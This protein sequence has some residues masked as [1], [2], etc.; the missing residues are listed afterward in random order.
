[1]T[2]YQCNRSCVYCY[3]RHKESLFMSPELAK[4]ILAKE[5][6]TCSNDGKTTSLEI[7]FMGGEPLLN[8]PLIK[9]VCNWIWTRQ[10]E[11]PY[12]L[13]VRTNGSLLDEEKQKWFW[14]N[15]SRI[16]MGLSMDGL[17]GMNRFNRG[18]FE[19]HLD[20]FRRTWPQVPVKV[21]L[22]PDSIDLL[23]ETVV[24]AEEKDVPLELFFAE[25]VE[26][27]PDSVRVLG[28]EYE[29]L[30]NHY[31]RQRNII[32]PR[33]LFSENLRDLYSPNNNEN[34]ER[35][36]LCGE[37]HNEVCYDVDGTERICHIFTPVTM[38]RDLADRARRELSAGDIAITE[39]SEC[40][41]CPIKMDCKRCFGF[42][43]LIRGDVSKNAAR[44]TTCLATWERARATALF[45]LKRLES[46]YGD[47][48]T[49]THE[50]IALGRNALRLLNETFR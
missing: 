15:S 18:E 14:R 10:C 24:E 19:T 30:I 50:Q 43:L 46:Q 12:S 27:T 39:D 28:G 37:S 47:K 20:F 49:P 3:E 44:V 26:W 25:G 1:M 2:T 45:F 35:L 34:S 42:N 41:R 13:F 16:K 22:F 8:F 4:E 9:D 31:L 48:P 21:V 32:P 17:S 6:V 38:G 11:L 7:S 5:F 36:V 40:I 33:G 29:K 23:A